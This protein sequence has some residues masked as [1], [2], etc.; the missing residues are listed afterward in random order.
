MTT[1]LTRALAWA[2]ATDAANR[3]MKRAGRTVWNLEDWKLAAAE[4]A[5]L[6]PEKPDVMSAWNV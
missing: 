2:A 6:W 1:T 5:R 3:H 4:F